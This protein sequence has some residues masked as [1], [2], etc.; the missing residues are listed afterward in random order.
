[1]DS[2]FEEM[3]RDYIVSTHWWKDWEHKD[4]L[5][6]G[7]IISKVKNGWE[8]SIQVDAEHHYREWFYQTVTTEDLFVWLYKLRTKR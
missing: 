4:C 2:D 6:L 1:M 7:D 8:V 3:I 5:I